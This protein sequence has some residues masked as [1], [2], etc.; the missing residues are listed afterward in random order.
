[1]N[2]H[3]RLHTKGTTEGNNN[4]HVRLLGR[5]TPFKP[6]ALQILTPASRQHHA[7]MRVLLQ[8]AGLA[9]PRAYPEH[10]PPPAHM[11]H[12]LKY[13]L[14][15]TAPHT[16]FLL[17]LPT[18]DLPVHTLLYNHCVN[19]E[20]PPHP[21]HSHLS[22]TCSHPCTKLLPPPITFTFRAQAVAPTFRFYS[23]TSSPYGA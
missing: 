22:C 14:H 17:S 10:H 11:L 8:T 3:C 4:T 21:Q 18:A 7:K 6:E 9:Q 20:L 16:L 2:S 5:S 13:M 12:V 1:M 15:L 23:R 19:T